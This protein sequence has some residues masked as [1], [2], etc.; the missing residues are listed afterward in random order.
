MVRTD[1]GGDDG[2]TA[3]AIQLDGKIVAAGGT[4][5][6][7]ALARYTPSG[8]LDRSFGNGGRVL[9]DVGARPDVYSRA[10][11]RGAAAV[12]VQRDGK[13]IAAGAGNGDF[14]LV[15]LTGRGRLDRTFGRNGRVVTDFQ[16]GISGGDYATAVAVQPDGKIVAVGRSDLDL[17]LARY[18]PD[19]RLDRSFGSGGKVLRHAGSDDI[20][21]AE[22]L[23]IE[24]DGTIVV[25]G[26]SGG[27]TPGSAIFVRFL[28]DGRLDRS[29]GTAMV[30]PLS[31]EANA[32]YGAIAVQDDGKL[33]AAGGGVNVEPSSNIIALSRYTPLGRLDPTFGRD[34]TVLT[35]LGQTSFRQLTAVAL[36]GD[37]KIVTAGFDQR[38]RKPGQFVLS[39]YTADGR[40]DD[41]F[42]T[43]GTVSTDVG[44]LSWRDSAP[45]TPAMAIQSDGKLVVAGGASSPTRSRD[46]VLVRYNP[47]GSLD[48]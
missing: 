40:L 46:F 37:G 13:I 17:A 5:G 41:S 43:R 14:A 3:V 34:G 2:A 26:G 11:Q 4:G 12:V 7:F 36:Q 32:H 21:D 44:S 47:D 20:D 48:S 22:A 35:N 30:S 8:R 27:H 24:A 31:V 42:A 18:L 15:R 29:F 25:G 28:R 10:W 16:G 45:Y 23:A 38:A 9:A 19:G 6:R 1:F 33:V 39:R